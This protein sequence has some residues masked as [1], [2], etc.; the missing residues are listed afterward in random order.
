MGGQFVS[1]ETDKRGSGWSGG[2]DILRYPSEKVYKKLD[3]PYLNR[4]F[5]PI[6]S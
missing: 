4:H 1:V 6:I 2:E 5:M 3:S